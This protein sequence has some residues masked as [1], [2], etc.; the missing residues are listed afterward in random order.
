M[1]TGPGPL[2]LAD[3]DL[4]ATGGFE[5]IPAAKYN[6]EIFKCNMDAVKNTDGTG[7]MPAGTPMIKVQF[8]ITDEPYVNR[9]VFSTYVI[10]PN[11]YD[12]KKAATMKGILANFFIAMGEK[13]ETIRSPE[14]N[15]DLESY[16]GLPCVVVVGRKQKK[17]RD[18]NVVEGEYDNPVN[19][20]KPAGSLTAATEAGGL[21]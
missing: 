16:V 11:D 10:P 6:A 5:A 17:D 19:G 4:S 12:Q 21:L 14:F 3:A 18:G 8:K 7:A 20:V 1:S 2:N 15:P 9:R 13:E